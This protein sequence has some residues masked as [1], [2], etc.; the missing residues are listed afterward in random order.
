MYVHASCRGGGSQHTRLPSHIV[1]A[2][3]RDRSE[4]KKVQA[5]QIPFANVRAH[6][7]VKAST[8]PNYKT[9][10]DEMTHAMQVAADFVTT[11]VAK[12]VECNALDSVQVV[13]L[14]KLKCC[15]RCF[16][17][18]LVSR[19]TTHTHTQWH[20]RAPLLADARAHTA[21]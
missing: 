8:D 10:L 14:V 9:F 17:C 1:A 4:V 5:W 13:F 7:H 16:L 18:L 12:T 19:F 3:V 11:S 2:R 15:A 20:R 6:M 21:F